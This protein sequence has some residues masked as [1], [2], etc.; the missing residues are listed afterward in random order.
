ME[1]ASYKKLK[2]SGVAIRVSIEPNAM[3]VYKS[4]AFEI[5]RRRESTIL[6]LDGNSAAANLI[7]D[8]KN[9]KHK[10]K[11]FISKHSKSLMTKAASLEG[12]INILEDDTPVQDVL[13]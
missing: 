2:A 3:G 8:A 13:S 10:C 1:E 12:Y 4:I 7:Q 11:I 6:A 9:S 5:F